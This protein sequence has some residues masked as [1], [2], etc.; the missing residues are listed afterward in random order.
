MSYI[1]PA[2]SRLVAGRARVVRLS[3]MRVVSRSGLWRV[4]FQVN[5]VYYRPFRRRIVG[6]LLTS[7]CQSSAR[8]QP[9]PPARPSPPS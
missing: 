4:G 8:P 9:L 5:E 2:P 3:V 6:P 1:G 7:A